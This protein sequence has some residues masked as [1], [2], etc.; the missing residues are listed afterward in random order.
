MYNKF[1]LCDTLQ[2]SSDKLRTMAA[3]ALLQINIPEWIT[4]NEPSFVPPVC[5]KLMHGDGQLKIMFIGGPNVRKDYHIEEGEELFYQI[6][7]D[8]VLKIIE[9]G[10]K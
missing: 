7:G 5:N 1:V 6:R 2:V 3:S 10:D 8:M 4:R 9:K